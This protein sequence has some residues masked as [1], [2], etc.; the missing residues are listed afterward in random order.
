[1]SQLVQ[2]LKDFS[3]TVA[4][5]SVLSTIGPGFSGLLPVDRLGIAI[6]NPSNT[7]F[8]NLAVWDRVDANPSRGGLFKATHTAGEW[9]SRFNCPAVGTDIEQMKP[10][11]ET[12]SYLCRERF[13][14]NLLLPLDLSR[15]GT[16]V[17]Y[18]LSAMPK[19]F[20]NESI[21]LGLRIKSIIEPAIRAY[22]A[23]RELLNGRD[24]SSVTPQADQQHAYEQPLSLEQIQRQHILAVLK[25]TNW[26]VEGS[27]G[28]AELLDVNPST[29]RNRMRRLGIKR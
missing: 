7:E 21:P 28:A 5:Q 12:Y 22:F 18:A 27:H 8:E 25:R 26:K 15:Y 4:P 13:N 16:G 19:G 9:V 24:E 14:S 11:P 3:A 23:T 6:M 2:S 17:L 1:M 10:Y 29:L 20:T